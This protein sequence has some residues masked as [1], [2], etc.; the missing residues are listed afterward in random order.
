MPVQA[1]GLF[2]NHR[3]QPR[4]NARQTGVRALDGRG[5]VKVG[6]I[7]NARDGGLPNRYALF[8]PQLV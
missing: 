1:S 6:Q 3:K 2:S 4:P 5:K 7:K 8:L